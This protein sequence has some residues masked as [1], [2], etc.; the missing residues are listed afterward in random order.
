MNMANSH[1]VLVKLRPSN[2]LRVSESRINLRRLYAPP[3]REIA[4]AESTPDWY[5][6][7][8]PETAPS[9]WDHAHSKLAMQL[10][11]SDS[12]VLFAEPDIE[13]AIYRDTNERP[14][15]AKFAVGQTCKA[16][17]QDGGHGKAQVPERF[18]WHLDDEFSE[19][20]SARESVEFSD[21]RT[22]IAH[23]DTGYYRAH[24]SVPEHIVRH[25][26]RDFVRRDGTPHTAED[27]DNFVLGLDNSGH[28]TGT[29]G[30]L[31][32]GKIPGQG[33]VYLGGA[34][35]AEVVPLRIADSV[36]LFRTS[37]FAEA[38]RFATAQRC[39]VVTLSMGGLPSRAWTEAINEAYLAGVCI[40]AAAGNNVNGIV[41]RHIVYPARYRRVIAVCGVMAD[42]RPYV[43]L[44]GLTTLEGNFGPESSMKVA[45]AAYTPNIPW[46]RYGCPDIIRLNG[47]GT[48]A[49]TPQVA[50]AA[51]LWFE[52]YKKELPR[53]WHRVEAVRNALFESAKDKNRDSKHFGRG[54]L[55]ARR[56][57]EVKPVLGLNQSPADSDSFAFLRVI[58]G[59]GIVEQPPR[60]QMLNLELAQRWLINP[61]LQEI[62]ADPEAVT[63]LGTAKRKQFMEAV[64]EDNAASMT[65]RRHVA[66]RYPAI[67]GSSAPHNDLSKTV[68]PDDKADACEK[69]VEL[70]R[71]AFRRLRVYA[72]DPS[73]STQ[74]DTAS[75]S[76]V[77]L[78]VRWEDNLDL[79]PSGEYLDVD[80]VDVSGKRYAKVNLNDPR[81][82]A[83]DG[84]SPSEGNPGFHQQMVYAVA[85]QTIE[86]FEQAL[87]RPV[88]WRH[89]K[90]PLKPDDDSKPT[91][92]L[93]VRPHALR[94]ANAFYS[95]DKVE[96][97]FGYFETGADDPGDHVPGSRVYACLSHDIIAHETTHAILD[98]LYRRFNESSN[99]DVL[100]FHEAFADIVA[101]MQHF[102]IAELLEREI[103]RSRGDL[104]TENTL[105]SLAIQFGRA[106]GGRGA[107]RDAI[108]TIDENGKW[109]RQRPG[110]SDYQKH[111]APHGR[112]SVLVAAVFDAFLAIY[113]ARSA[114]LIRIYTSGTGVLGEGAIHPDLVRR[115]AAEASKSAAHVLRM[116][117]RALDYLPPVDITFGEYLRALITGDFDLIA[118]DKY[119][120]RVAFVEAFRKRGIYPLDI[121][122][123]GAARTL[124][125][126]T[127]RWQSFDLSQLTNA[128]RAA[129]VPEYAAAVEQLK[130][131]A[132]ECLYLYD[133]DE[134]F[135]K[136]RKH[137]RDIHALLKRAFG[138]SPKFA[139]GLGLDID[140]K[141]PIF[142]VHALRRALRVTA[143]GRHVP[144]VVVALTQSTKIPEKDGTPAH[145]FRGGTT[146]VLDLSVND[147]DPERIIRYSIGKNIANRD[148]RL[149]TAEFKRQ[150]ANDALRA[151]LFADDRPEPFAA[152]HAFGDGRT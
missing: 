67:V 105:G 142:E 61:R 132:D 12:D 109:T 10:G 150:T 47:E 115:L 143:E 81:M 126:D 50:A 120:Y 46:A 118:D 82:L 117:I 97:L 52:K 148:R 65:L 28:G 7:D 72:L 91:T 60:E 80:D 58:T 30:I 136:T 149:R 104:A 8:L 43:H 57:L 56:A 79:G 2:A 141:K 45:I 88:L 14:G 116:C 74:L 106:M 40:V 73:F 23:I 29:I 146:L 24:A 13:H 98:G 15:E 39:D 127:L 96:L 140:P 135:K 102:T 131:Y 122:T 83:S 17:A 33:N 34:P 125:V 31:A 147:P 1:R 44:E 123:P 114:D 107:L 69:E 55:Q 41:T 68:V 112:G 53:E 151:L 121:G 119:H 101:L 59:L 38:I 86:H 76:E 94:Q 139:A 133:R 108:G 95:P 78:K 18:A 129:I 26:E 75:I 113:N 70:G 11:I 99:P 145:V 110:A 103:S 128:E 19:L 49:A 130:R 63:D 3:A 111:L 6:A 5:V 48:S 36:A 4:F 51:A 89:E 87:G 16:E 64:I 20:K 37:A 9:P 71:P 144:Q 90:N 138:K 66:A 85:M 77:T 137:R 62:V 84:W 134:L 93:K 25:L 35:H 21:P 124:S 22:R 100:A 54:I 92:K 152:L 32:G 27:P 42:G